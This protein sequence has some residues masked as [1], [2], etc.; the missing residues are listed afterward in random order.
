MDK[1]IKPEMRD[2]KPY[3]IWPGFMSSGVRSKQGSRMVSRAMVMCYRYGMK[4]GVVS[5]VVVVSYGH[6]SFLGVV[7]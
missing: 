1:R 4:S 3:S 6:G 7:T 5:R 2:F